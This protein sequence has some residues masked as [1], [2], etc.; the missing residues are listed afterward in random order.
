MNIIV[1]EDSESPEPAGAGEAGVAAAMSAT[2]NG[3]RRATGLEPSYTPLLHKD[4]LPFEP[5]PAGPIPPSPTDSL[6]FLY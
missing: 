2:V 6:E 5:Y 4:P 3:W 1:L